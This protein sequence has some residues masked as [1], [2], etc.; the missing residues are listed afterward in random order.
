MILQYDH[1][2]VRNGNLPSA[3]SDGIT[4]CILKEGVLILLKMPHFSGSDRQT[5]R[6]ALLVHT[7][8]VIKL[9]GKTCEM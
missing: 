9:V 2:S 3:G 6:Q 4:S 8:R 5:D 7:H 1:S